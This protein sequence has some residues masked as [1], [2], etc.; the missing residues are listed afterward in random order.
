[1]YN[2]WGIV[3]E[4]NTGSENSSTLLAELEQQ[5]KGARGGNRKGGIE[6]RAGRFPPFANFCTLRRKD[7]L[8]GTSKLRYRHKLKKGWYAGS[9]GFRR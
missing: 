6:K 1:M 9:S 7:K 5:S 2:R 8:V 3:G 4:Q